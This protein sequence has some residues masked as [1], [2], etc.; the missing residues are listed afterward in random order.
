MDLTADKWLTLVIGV[1]FLIALWLVLYADY[2]KLPEL[3]K[4]FETNEI[5]QLNKARWP[6]KLPMHRAFRMGQIANFLSYSKS[7]I[8]LGDV[9]EDEVAS[10]PLPLKRWAIWPYY[11]LYQVFILMGLHYVLYRL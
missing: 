10:V 9:T 3:E 2:V 5:V 7:Y 4:Y 1:E 6:S 8:R 11:F